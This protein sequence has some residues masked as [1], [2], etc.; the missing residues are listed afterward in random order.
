MPR[1][2]ADKKLQLPGHSESEHEGDD[3]SHNTTNWT[4][5]LKSR[6]RSIGVRRDV[7]VRRLSRLV[8]ICRASRRLGRL[9]LRFRSSSRGGSLAA[10]P[11][12]IPADYLVGHLDIHRRADLAS[13]L[14]GLALALLVAGL[15]DAASNTI[16]EFLV[17]AY[18]G[19]VKLVTV[20][21]LVAGDI[22]GDARSL[23]AR[24][25]MLA[26]DA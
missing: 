6:V 24:S 26:S 13:V 18:A 20:G 8:I 25:T 23:S 15:R 3:S 17:T 14:D 7:L 9:G 21:N 16:K 22:S 10:R 4:Q 11:A 1:H 12:R 19:N 2:T 5:G